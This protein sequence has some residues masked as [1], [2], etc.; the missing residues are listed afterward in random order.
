MVVQYKQVL[1]S[2]GD[3]FYLF[4]CGGCSSSRHAAAATQKFYDA[5]MT[6]E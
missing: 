1:E 3:A 5:V 6:L 2:R 4:I